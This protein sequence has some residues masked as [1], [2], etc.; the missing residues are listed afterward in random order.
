[1]R[2]LAAVP[3]LKQRVALT[4]AY[5]AGLRVSEVARLKIADI[6]SRRMVIRVEQGKGGKDRYIMLSPHLLRILRRYYRLL[7]PRHWLFPGHDKV[8]ARCAL[9][10]ATTPHP[11]PAA[12]HPPADAGISRSA[13]IPIIAAGRP[14]FSQLGFCEV[15]PRLAGAFLIR[16]PT[17]ASGFPW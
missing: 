6:D 7:R 11:T 5:A 17:E 1:V 13:T 10:P 3:N 2:F 8:P 12:P 4:T 15:T 16:D 14:R 9:P